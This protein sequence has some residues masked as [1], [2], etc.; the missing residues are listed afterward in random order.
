MSGEQA[1]H[2]L[3]SSGWKFID[4]DLHTLRTGWWVLPGSGDI[5]SMRR[6]DPGLY[7]ESALKAIDLYVEGAE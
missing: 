5:R 6:G 2:I 4:C 7:L 1:V 3:Q